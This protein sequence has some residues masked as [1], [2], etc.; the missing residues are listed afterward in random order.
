MGECVIT[1]RGS[2]DAYEALREEV[3][4]FAAEEGYGRD[5]C[6]QLQLSL[7]ELFVNAVRH[8]NRG[9][10]HLRITF[11]FQASLEANG[12]VLRVSV[13]D[14]GSGFALADL[15]DPTSPQFLLRSSGRGMYII[16]S[17]AEIV[18]VERHG[19]GCTLRLRYAPY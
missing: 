7:K 6:G 10:E 19:P 3:R 9:M 11:R 4:L 1:V 15:A 2:V 13:T 5:F 17:I 14:C 16:S 12:P 18:G 8:G